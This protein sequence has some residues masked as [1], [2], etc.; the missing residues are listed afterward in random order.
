MGAVR[1]SRSLPPHIQWGG[2]TAGCQQGGSGW[3]L[4][5]SGHHPVKLKDSEVVLKIPSS[6][7]ALYSE[8]T[9]SLSRCQKRKKKE[10]PR[11]TANPC[12]TP[13][14]LG[15]KPIAGAH[16]AG[17]GWTKRRP[18]H[19][20]QG[21]FLSFP[22]QNCPLLK[23]SCCSDVGGAAPPPLHT[24]LKTKDKPRW[25]GE[26]WGQ[27]L[28]PCTLPKCLNARRS[29]PRSWQLSVIIPAT[30]R[31][32]A[33]GSMSRAGER[34]LPGSDEMPVFV[35]AA[36]SR[37]CRPQ[38]GTAS[39]PASLKWLS[40]LGQAFFSLPRGRGLSHYLAFITEGKLF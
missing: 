7:T 35:P 5:R 16:K 15:T 28:L 13:L 6:P 12:P 20:R 22:K 11:N 27:L 26:A 30:P 9:K 3:L 40:G 25:G 39:L 4:Y 21:A 37:P 36:A 32:P 17:E 33:P 38:G 34:H 10:N 31:A 2:K 19:T 1:N 14:P 29:R 18:G 8:I 23:H 24:N